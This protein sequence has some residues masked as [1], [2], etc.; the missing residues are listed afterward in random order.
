MC[1]QIPPETIRPYVRHLTFIGDFASPGDLYALGYWNG[2]VS[3]LPGEEPP[4]FVTAGAIHS[5]DRPFGSELM[6]FPSIRS[7]QFSSWGGVPWYAL[8]KCME[9]PRIDS[10]A[11][12]DSPW[13]CVSPP[14]AS[15]QVPTASS[16]SNLSYEVSPWRGVEGTIRRWD[17]QAAHELESSYLQKL[18]P[19]IANRAES[20]TLPME[21][22]PFALMATFEWP[23]LRALSLASTQLQPTQ[24]IQLINVIEFDY[25]KTG[26]EET[27]AT[28]YGP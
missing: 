11:I 20:L 12:V 4:A 14:P 26:L 5:D 16:V 9:C 15:S 3:Y 22:A 21:T 27:G 1:G 8:Q 23:R 6:I 13:T 2:Q 28:I 24:L 25:Y 18:I 19:G 7:V 17:M 10:I